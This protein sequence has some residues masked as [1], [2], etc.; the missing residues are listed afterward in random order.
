MKALICI[1]HVPDTT[2]KIKFT[3]NDTKFD[4]TDIKYIIGP[5]EELA[6]TRLLDLR[7]AG[8]EMHITTVTVGLQDT[9]P[10][11]RKALAMGADDA[12]RVN[13]EPLDDYYVA[14]QIAEVFKNGDYDF[15]VTGKE[16]ID[17][18]G[19]RLDGMIAEFLDLPSI[20]GASKFDID[21]GKIKAEQEIEGG[22]L[23]LDVSGKFVISAGKGFCP[24][25]EPRIPNMRGIMTAR[26]KPLQVT[27]PAEAEALTETVKYHLPEPKP[28]CKMIDPENPEE[29]VKLLHEEA[30]VI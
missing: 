10:T 8:N 19:S 28:A 18:N 17:H 22:T 21:N 29:L 2:S 26:K 24:E 15:I 4:T 9:E 27:E 23:V 13:A 1:G 14:K 30:K 25:P 7:D 6:L 16:S 5:Y 20:S 11:I 3:D 12:V